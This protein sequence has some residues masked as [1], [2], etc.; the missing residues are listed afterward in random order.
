MAREAGIVDEHVDRAE[1]RPNPGDRFAR[2]PRVCDI[3]DT[4]L[5]GRALSA[6]R[7]RELYDGRRP[8][9][10]ADRRALLARC[11]QSAR[12]MPPAAPVTTTTLPTKSFFAAVTPSLSGTSMAVAGHRP[13]TRAAIVA[14]TRACQS[15]A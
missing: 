5:G 10:R 8:I 11:R 6:Q 9:E 7:L 12:P 3:D 4:S 15:W 1:L 13:A 14:L 2:R